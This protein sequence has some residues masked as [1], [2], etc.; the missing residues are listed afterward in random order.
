MVSHTMVGHTCEQRW[1]FKIMVAYYAGTAIGATLLSSVGDPSGVSVGASGA[2]LG[3]IGANV[4]WLLVDWHNP[5]NMCH[6]LV[7]LF[8]IFLFGISS[9]GA[10]ITGRT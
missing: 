4:A 2:L 6:M 8:I 5:D 7:W 10:S 1:G 9:E 3:I